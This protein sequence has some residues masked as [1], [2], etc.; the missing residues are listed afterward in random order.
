MHGWAGSGWCSCASVAPDF[1]EQQGWTGGLPQTVWERGG[2]PAL[3][4]GP[5][6][7][8]S[9]CN[10]YGLYEPLGLPRACTGPKGFERVPLGGAD[11]VSIPEEW[12]K[13]WCTVLHQRVSDVARVQVGLIVLLLIEG[14]HRPSNHLNVFHRPLLHIVPGEKGKLVL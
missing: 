9:T 8:P 13:M 3:A 14:I 11:L 2:T 5:G 1:L 12:L 4:V 6:R 7:N 10:D